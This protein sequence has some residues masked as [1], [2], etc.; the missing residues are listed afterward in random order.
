MGIKRKR[1]GPGKLEHARRIADTQ[2]LGPKTGDGLVDPD[3]DDI[4]GV[5]QELREHR[6]MNDQS[7]DYD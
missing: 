5:E 4:E 3:F 2:Y 6:G 7:E 1:G